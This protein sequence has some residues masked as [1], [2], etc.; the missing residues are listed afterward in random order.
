MNDK[1]GGTRVGM[2]GGEQV[3]R[4]SSVAN[5]TLSQLYPGSTHESSLGV[6]TNWM[7]RHLNMRDMFGTN[8]AKG[9]HVGCSKD[10]I[11]LDIYLVGMDAV[12]VLDMIVSSC[13]MV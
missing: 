10:V 1:T 13:L 5:R 11:A 3:T 2:V 9:P 8:R 7:S 12:L 4:R 6:Q